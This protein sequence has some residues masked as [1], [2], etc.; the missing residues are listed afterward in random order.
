MR[1]AFKCRAYPTPEQAALLNRTFGCIRVVWNRTLADRHARYHRGDGSTSYAETD[2]QLT[3]MKTD[4]ETAWLAEVSSVPLQQALRHQHTAFTAFFQKHARY[5]RFKSRSARQSASFTRSAFRMKGTDLWLAKTTGPLRYV[6]SWPNTDPG[7]LNP[8]TVTVSR[9]PD[10]RWFA[11]FAVDVEAP[12]APAPTGKTVGADLGLTD[13][14]VLSTGERIAHPRNMDRHE[15]RL[16]RYQ[17]ALARKQRGSANRRK[18]KQKV[19]RCHSRVRDARR[20]FL[21]QRS[22]AL[23]RRFDAIAVED[24]NVVGMVRNRR[25]AKAIS[26]TGWAEF[27]NL[28]EYKA[29]RNGRTL[30]VVDRWYP[31]SKTCSTCGHLLATLSL[32]TRHWTCPN[33]GTLHDR[34]VNAAKNIKVAAGL[35]ETQ[36]ACGADVRRAGATPAQSAVKQ[37]HQPAKVGLP[38]H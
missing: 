36:N 30:A 33:C 2:R 21:H 8:S 23:V 11:T 16:K 22:T 27:R 35:V 24:L 29:H 37:E 17:R 32:G 7:T 34:D 26:R 28:L 4:P 20:D 1:T 18:A 9:D 12:A 38:R 14:A 5:P 19:A 15:R 6:W 25:L 13:F 3:A 10:G 31:S